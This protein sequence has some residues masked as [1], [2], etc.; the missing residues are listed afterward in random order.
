ML[1]AAVRLVG[2]VVAIV[3]RQ[4]V[5][6]VLSAANVP[7]GAQAQPL[8]EDKIQLTANLIVGA[9]VAV[10]VLFAALFVL[11]AWNWA[12]AQLGARGDQCNG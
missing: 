2:V 5:A 11:F 10:S 3:T 9:N 1:T 7:A 12:P 6:D 4:A 8:S